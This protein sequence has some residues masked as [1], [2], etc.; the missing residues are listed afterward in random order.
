[1]QAGIPEG[2]LK[3]VDDCGRLQFL[4]WVHLSAPLKAGLF[5][6]SVGSATH[7]N[8]VVLTYP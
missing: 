5:C 1:L 6:A 7:G 3:T 2:I 4:Y 8:A